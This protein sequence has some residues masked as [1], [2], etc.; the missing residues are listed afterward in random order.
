MTQ[1]I[2]S[3]DTSRNNLLMVAAGGLISG[4]LTPLLPDA[5]RPCRWLARPVSHFADRGAVCRARVHS[6]AALQRQS[7]LGGDACRCC[8]HGRVRLRGERSHLHRGTDCRRCRGHAL[9]ACRID[10]RAGRHRRDG[11]RD[12]PAAGGAAR[13]RRMVADADHGD[14]RRDAAGARQCARP[15]QHLVPLSGLA[16]GGG[17]CGFRWC[18]AGSSLSDKGASHGGRHKGTAWPWPRYPPSRG[19]DH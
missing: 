7:A 4:I 16:G 8:H 6:G 17:G 11:A 12:R 5:D 9:S 3:T 14:A 1:A 2:A 19:H 13:G 18:C 10:R 15:R